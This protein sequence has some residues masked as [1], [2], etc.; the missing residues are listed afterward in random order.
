MENRLRRRTTRLGRA[1]RPSIGAGQPTGVEGVLA[2]IFRAIATTR[3]MS[4]VSFGKLV[5][6][7]ISRS[8]RKNDSKIKKNGHRGNLTK[9]A[10]SDKLTFRSFCTLSQ[11]LEIVDQ[12]VIIISTFA[13]GQVIQSE[14]T[15]LYSG[16]ADPEDID[17]TDLE[18]N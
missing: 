17:N 10:A 2:N 18:E 13:D 1:L 4:E 16:H 14:Q 7:F 9:A 6:S 3:N 5:S 11:V 15:I 12:K 8:D